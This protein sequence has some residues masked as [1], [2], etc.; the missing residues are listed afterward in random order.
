MR[1][2]FK[3]TV[4]NEPTGRMLQ[5]AQRAV[6]DRTDTSTEHGLASPEARLV[7]P[8]SSAVSQRLAAGQQ[9]TVASGAFGVVCANMTNLQIR[10]GC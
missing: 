9:R 3:A 10:C 5:S 6:V 4:L 7:R 1:A 8:P 2:L